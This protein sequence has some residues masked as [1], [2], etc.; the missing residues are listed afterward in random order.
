MS[1]GFCPTYIFYYFD[2]ISKLV[3][4]APYPIKVIFIRYFFQPL[5]LSLKDMAFTFIFLS[6]IGTTPA[7]PTDMMFLLFA[8]PPPLKDGVGQS[9]LYVCT[10]DRNFLPS[11]LCLASI[12]Y[13]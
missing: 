3:F 4:A 5:S 7:F 1:L 2:N 6:V 8:L 9:L 13:Q 10:Y 12:P 11:A